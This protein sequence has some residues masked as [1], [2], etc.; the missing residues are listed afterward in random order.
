MKTFCLI[1]AGGFAS[2]VYCLLTDL[3]KSTQ[4]ECFMETSPSKESFMGLPVKPI[5]SFDP[6]KNIAVI[7]VG[8]PVQK[9]TLIRQLPKNTEF[10]T[11][12]HPTVIMS[13]FVEVGIGSIICAGSILTCN[14]KLGKFVHL[15]LNT[16][17]GHDCVIG[18]YATTAPAV[19]LSGNTDI[20]DNVYMGTNSAIREKIN[21][22]D[23]VVIGMGAIVVNDLLTPGIYIGNPAKKLERN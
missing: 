4:T 3:G 2:E 11:L 9:Q 16:T 23:D 21:I 18:D 8:D 15:N 5:S 6:D 20:G 7:C 17:V 22:V 12:I 13:K 1:G 14:I 10:E 19:N